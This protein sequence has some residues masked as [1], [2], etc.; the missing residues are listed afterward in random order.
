MTDRKPEIPVP[1]RIDAP[2]ESLDMKEFERRFFSAIHDVDEITSLHIHSC[3][4]LMHGFADFLCVPH[5]KKRELGH[6]ASLHDYGKFFIS[7]MVL[8]KQARLTVPENDI[9]Q[10]HPAVGYV[11]LNQVGQVPNAALDMALCHHERWDGKGYP[12]G[13][14]G[15]STPIAARICSIVDAADAM[16]SHRGY[17]RIK[18]VEDVQNEIA[19]NAGSQF[20][21]VLSDCFVQFMKETRADLERHYQHKNILAHRYLDTQKGQPILI[22]RHDEDFQDTDTYWHRT[23]GS[24][25]DIIG[26]LEQAYIMVDRR[27]REKVEMV[28]A[29]INPVCFAPL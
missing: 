3:K 10:A 4:R 24:R 14:E 5:E 25:L 12:F 8:K 22:D 19:M 23:L 18:S 15:D 21:P 28:M 11:L 27:A 20:D 6:G 29:S 17:N 13:L 9:A 2:T 16:L 26:V 1:F 7:E